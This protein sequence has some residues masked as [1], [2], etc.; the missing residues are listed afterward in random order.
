MTENTRTSV[1]IEQIISRIVMR[2]AGFQRWIVSLKLFI[3]IY[4]KAHVE[5]AFKMLALNPK[6]LY[7]SVLFVVR[8]IRNMFGPDHYSR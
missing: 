6:K 4:Y 2:M 7:L 3:D 5:A 8:E 1:E